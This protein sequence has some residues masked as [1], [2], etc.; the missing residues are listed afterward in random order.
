MLLVLALYGL[1]QAWGWVPRG[2]ARHGMILWHISLGLLLTAVVI[3]RILWRVGP[4]RRVLPARTGWVE[5]AGQGMHYLLYALLAAQIV[6]GFLYRW[7]DNVSLSF[8]GLF[9]IPPL[10]TLT[11]QQHHLVAQLHNWTAYLI[12]GFAGLHAAAALLHHFVLHDDVLLRMLPGRRAPRPA[13]DPRRPDPRRVE[14][15]AD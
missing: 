12:L 1:S 15:N 14:Q 13:S 11:K 8:F 9:G 6:L 3:L 4:G 10:V 5:R 7:S 2:P